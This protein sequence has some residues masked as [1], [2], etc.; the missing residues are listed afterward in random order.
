MTSL[1]NMSKTRIDDKIIGD[2]E[3]MRLVFE[4]DGGFLRKVRVYEFGQA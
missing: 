2:I 3:K 1:E 4:K